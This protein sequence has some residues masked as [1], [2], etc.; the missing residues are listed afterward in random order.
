VIDFS[1]VNEEINESN[2]FSRLSLADLLG[3]LESSE[4]DYLA[5]HFHELDRNFLK[6]LS[7]RRLLEVVS[8]EKFVIETEDSL[9]AFL[10][11]L[12]AE[13]IGLLGYLGSEYLSVSGIDRLLKSLSLSEVDATLWLSLCCR[14]RLSVQPSSNLASRYCSY[15]GSGTG[16]FPFVLSRPFDGIISNLTRKCGGNVHTR[17]L[18][19]VT[20][21]T[22]AFRHCHEVADYNWTSWLS[23]ADEA[24]AWI[25]F[26]FKNQDLGHKLHHQIRRE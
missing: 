18:I 3:I 23:S 8:S 7:H 20:A 10:L 24:D 14:R 1:S 2:V 25:Q 9:L 26:D 13:Y 11:E 6:S 5:S 12:G 16:R 17:G 22:S 15:A 4:I 19:A 21:S